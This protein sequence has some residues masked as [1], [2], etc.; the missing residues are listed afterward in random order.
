MPQHKRKNCT[1][2]NHVRKCNYIL[3]IICLRDSDSERQIRGP[4][5][6]NVTC[7]HPFIYALLWLP[8]SITTHT[9]PLTLTLLLQLTRSPNPT[10]TVWRSTW[11]PLVGRLVYLPRCDSPK[12]F[13]SE[14]WFSPISSFSSF[15]KERVLNARQVPTVSTMYQLHSGLFNYNF[16]AQGH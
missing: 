4:I 7:T 2:Q 5:E 13:S 9:L 11:R 6:G 14:A 10:D 15:F 1:F 12:L 16:G 3:H 8:I